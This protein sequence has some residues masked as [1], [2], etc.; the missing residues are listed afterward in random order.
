MYFKFSLKSVKRIIDIWIIISY[1][2]FIA[3]FV[4]FLW[5]IGCFEED[6]TIYLLC[7]PYSSDVQSILLNQRGQG[8]LMNVVEY[9]HNIFRCEEKL[10]QIYS[11]VFMIFLIIN[12]IVFYYIYKYISFCDNESRRH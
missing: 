7:S 8:G 1:V 10:F 3:L 4:K 6:D 11:I 5:G 2:L 9:L 12:R